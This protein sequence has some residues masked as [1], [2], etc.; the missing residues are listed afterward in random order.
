MRDGT[1]LLSLIVKYSPDQPREANGEFG[2]GSSL[3]ASEGHSWKEKN[4]E[5][6]Y[7]ARLSSPSGSMVALVTSPSGEGPYT[8]ST[9]GYGPTGKYRTKELAVAAANTFASSGKLPSGRSPKAYSD[10]SPIKSKVALTE[11]N[12][13]SL[14]TKYSTATKNDTSITEAL[15][16]YADTEYVP[17]NESLRGGGAIP[18]EMKSNIALLDKATSLGILSEESTLS[19]GVHG[20]P[21]DYIAGQVVRDPAFLSTTAL[22]QGAGDYFDYNHMLHITAPAGTTGAF[23]GSIGG[24]PE[25]KEVLL[26]RNTALRIDRV[27]PSPTALGVTHVY[28]TIV[29]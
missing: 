21:G 27:V 19:R 28:A 5:G 10:I 18:D 22:Q 17:I 3:P 1:T 15:Q 4:S 16:G 9:Y 24:R 14:A 8:V 13:S 20:E 26:P 7:S 12:Y 23:I 11:K 29:K 2:E 25:E 6:F